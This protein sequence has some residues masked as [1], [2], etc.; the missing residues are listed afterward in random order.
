MEKKERKM[1][2]SKQRMKK[3]WR[4]RNRG[5]KENKEKNVSEGGDGR[6]MRWREN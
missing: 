3:M 6:R 2:K 4:K 1:K 5:V